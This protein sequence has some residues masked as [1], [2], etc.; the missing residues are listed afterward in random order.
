MMNIIDKTVVEKNIKFVVNRIVNELDKNEDMIET[1]N[2]ASRHTW[3]L[4]DYQNVSEHMT[5]EEFTPINVNTRLELT[6]E[7]WV[8]YFERAT[9]GIAP[10]KYYSIESHHLLWGYENPK[11]Q[12]SSEYF[13]PF[14]KNTEN[15][16]NNSSEL[17][18]ETLWNAICEG[19]NIRIHG[20]GSKYKILEWIFDCLIESSYHQ[21]INS[22]IIDCKTIFTPIL[23]G[24]RRTNTNSKSTDFILTEC[25]YTILRYCDRNF[26]ICSCESGAPPK[27]G[28]MS[29]RDKFD[30]L[31][32]K[33]SGTCSSCMDIKKKC[34]NYTNK[35]KTLIDLKSKYQ[36]ELIVLID[37]Y[38]ELPQGQLD[39]LLAFSNIK[40]QD[41][42]KLFQYCI[43]S[44]FPI[45]ED[46]HIDAAN[47]S[48]ILYK[49]FKNEMVFDINI[50]DYNL[51]SNMDNLPLWCL[52]KTT[53]EY[54][55]MDDPYDSDTDSVDSD[56]NTDVICTTTITKDMKDK[57]L[58]ALG[59]EDNKRILNTLESMQKDIRFINCICKNRCETKGCKRPFI[60]GK[61]LKN[62]LADLGI[63]ETIFKQRIKDLANERLV[64][65]EDPDYFRAV[66][67]IP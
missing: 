44:D 3:S 20:S 29:K 47:N 21:N 43:T 6:S 33:I 53:E 19:I 59:N 22:T 16:K 5:D 55:D 54:N 45:P 42:T 40:L 64:E 28:R 66:D 41:G 60:D 58:Q 38:H 11:N 14:T 50:A 46:N 10:P 12:R 62:K 24:H 37:G 7:P 57:A 13:W 25:L 1:S 61:R 63:S 32:L 56:N 67:V 27:K 65:R 26:N 35:Y 4:S 39:Q 17:R 9:R 48:L 23:D 30:T 51:S 18:L 2:E 49:S 36:K 8:P 52:N 31:I 15:L 34:R